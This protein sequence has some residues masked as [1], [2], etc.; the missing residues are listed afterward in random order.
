MEE[1]KAHIE[2]KIAPYIERIQHLESSLSKKE[3]EII[4]LKHTVQNLQRLAQEAEK[5]YPPK[6]N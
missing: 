1:V 2:T 5:K 6:K 4:L 3:T